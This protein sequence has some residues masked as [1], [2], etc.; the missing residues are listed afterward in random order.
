M[1][2]AACKISSCPNHKKGLCTATQAT[3]HLCKKVG[4]Y[5]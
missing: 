1:S 4:G 3:K 5:Q 2:V